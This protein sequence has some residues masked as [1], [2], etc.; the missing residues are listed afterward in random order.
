MV[1]MKTTNDYRD[2]NLPVADRVT[3]LLGRMPLE[4]KVAQVGSVWGPDLLE[5]ER[6]SAEK[7]DTILCNGIGHVSRLGTASTL[8]P[9][10][11]ASTANEIQRYILEKTRLGIPALLHEE[12]CAG[13][14]A[15]EATQFPQAIGLASTWEPDLVQSMADVIREEMV[16]VGARHTL[17]PV[18][19]VARD[20]R[21]G[22]C[23]ESFGED[24]Y[25]VGRM[26]VAYVRGIQG[27]SL[28]Y[29]VA[30]T[31]KHFLGYGAP[32]GGM[33]W[34]P[35]QLPRRELFERILP[36]FEAAVREYCRKL[37]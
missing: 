28:A 8:R 31:G 20:P 11:L 19:D 32:E 36:P 17:A 21:W 2:P 9:V 30:A 22:R 24:P 3:D 4:E 18:L 12:S 37:G 14:T 25:L 5:G 6:F 16:A 23:E 33:N 13:L 27:A 34:A 15:R 10:E 7:A 35:C 1:R 26:G 29:G